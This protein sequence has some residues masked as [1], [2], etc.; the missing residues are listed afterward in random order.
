MFCCHLVTTLACPA[1]KK[2]I[3][4]EYDLNFIRN[5]RSF[6]SG[7]DVTMVG[8]SMVWIGVILI[9]GS[10]L[11]KP[12]NLPYYSTP[13]AVA[14]VNIIDRAVALNKYPPPVPPP[15][16]KCSGSPQ[17]RCGFSCHANLGLSFIVGAAI[18][19]FAFGRFIYL[20]CGG[21]DFGDD[22]LEAEAN[23]D[24]SSVESP[25][26]V[27]EASSSSCESPSSA[28]H[29]EQPVSNMCANEPVASVRSPCVVIQPMTK[30][31]VNEQITACESTAS[32]VHLDDTVTKIELPLTTPE[33]IT[34]EALN[35]MTDPIPSSSAEVSSSSCEISSKDD[36]FVVRSANDSQTHHVNYV[37]RALADVA[38]AEFV[39][40]T[41][42]DVMKNLKLKGVFE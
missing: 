29:G 6:W 40:A 11:S 33:K 3:K 41:V 34:P 10:V 5:K 14:A 31:C 15:C 19:V 24:S 1:S 13:G 27:P 30:I 42:A 26:A 8:A 12:F 17:D 25:A 21:Q 2:T 16:D 28:G 37:N 35:Q 7:A 39:R 20:L 38:H 23:K 32:V 22:D 36:S 18:F 4:T 9:Y